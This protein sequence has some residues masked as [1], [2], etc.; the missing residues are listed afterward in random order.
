LV[1]REQ[2]QKKELQEVGEDFQA[3]VLEFGSIPDEESQHLFHD[4]LVMAKRIE[5]WP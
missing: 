2:S 3:L 5:K 1:C 4:L